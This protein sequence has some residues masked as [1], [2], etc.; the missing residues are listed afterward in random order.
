MG[1]GPHLQSLT[2]WVWGRVCTSFSLWPQQIA[3]HLL[4]WTT[5]ISDGPVLQVRTMM[6]HWPKEMTRPG[7]ASR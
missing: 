1:C 4:A 6:C 5:H 7:P 2:Q 3:T